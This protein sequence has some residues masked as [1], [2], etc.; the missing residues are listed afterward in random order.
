LSP[1]AGLAQAKQRQQYSIHWTLG[2]SRV[3]QA[4]MNDEVNLRN[5]LL[6]RDEHNNRARLINRISG[7]INQKSILMA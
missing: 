3:G 1:C 5:Q 2:W 4:D 7:L 6:A